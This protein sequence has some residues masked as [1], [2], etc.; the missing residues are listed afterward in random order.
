MP[1]HRIADVLGQ[2]GEILGVSVRND[3]VRNVVPMRGHRFFA[4]AAD[5][6][7]TPPQRDLTGHRDVSAHRNAC[8]RARQRRRQRDAG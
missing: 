6:Q 5:G 8:Q 3:H 1:R 2:L 4:Q 7:H